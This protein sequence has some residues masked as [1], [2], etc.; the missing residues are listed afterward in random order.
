MYRILALFFL[1]ASLTSCEND[2]QTVKDVTMRPDLPIRTAHNT[3]ILYSDSA[4]VKVKLTAP[5]LDQYIGDNPRIVMPKGVNV[6]F[7]NDSLVVTTH[8]TA[9]SAIRLEKQGVMEAY[10][11]VVVVNRK[12]EKLHTEKLI[13]DEKRRIIYTDKHV[14][15]NTADDDILEGEGLEANEDFT[16]YKIKRPT[17]D[18][19]VDEDDKKP[20]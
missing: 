8:L 1:L 18:K 15:I 13:W 17:G 12:G 10:R 9:D 5:L 16:N 4:H 3:E 11:K 6:S 14:L 19:S 7:Y 2:M 20:K